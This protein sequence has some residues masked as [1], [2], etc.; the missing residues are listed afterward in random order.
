MATNNHRISKCFRQRRHADSI[1]PCSQRINRGGHGPP[2]SL[3]RIPPRMTQRDIS[4]ILNTSSS[5]SRRQ[6]VRSSVRG[7]V[8]ITRLGRNL[9]SLEPSWDSRYEREWLAMHASRYCLDSGDSLLRCN[10]HTSCSS[11][12][13]I[14]G[15]GSASWLWLLPRSSNVEYCKWVVI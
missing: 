8:S 1:P 5:V 2:N 3:V 4:T 9:A 13:I 10:R 7:P 6:G 15:P 12:C 11:G 14:P